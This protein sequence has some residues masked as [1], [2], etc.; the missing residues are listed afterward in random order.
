MLSDYRVIL[1][2]ASEGRREIF[3]KFFK[4]FDVI[5]SNVDEDVVSEKLKAYKNDPIMLSMYLSYVKNVDIRSK[6]IDVDKFVLFTFDTIVVHQGEIKQKPKDKKVAREWFYSYRGDFQ[7]IITSYSIYISDVNVT[8]N[9]YD[10]ST[11]YFKNVPDDEIERYIQ[12]NPVTTWAG[13]IAIE[14]ARNFFEIIDGDV[15]SIIGAPMS[16]MK[17]VL[18]LLVS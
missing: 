17:E 15:Y 1:G 12:E 7:E 14:R 13:G 2:S 11:V 16:K 4:K 5:V 3:S 6:I 10:L 9:D 18:S 8:I